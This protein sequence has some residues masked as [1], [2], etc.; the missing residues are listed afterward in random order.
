MG[1]FLNK[2]IEV[3]NEQKEIRQRATQVDSRLTTL[4]S[5]KAVVLFFVVAKEYFLTYK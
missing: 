4:E 5:G 3:E 1:D 2:L